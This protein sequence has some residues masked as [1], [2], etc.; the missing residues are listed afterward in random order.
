MVTAGMAAGI[1]GS[2]GLGGAAAGDLNT[3]VEEEARR[4]W[5]ISLSL[6]SL[7]LPASC[8]RVRAGSRR[9]YDARGC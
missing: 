9:G 2:C 7:L 5:S 1:T 4:R 6:L 8:G 3:V